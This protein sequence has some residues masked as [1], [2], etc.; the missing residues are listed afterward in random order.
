MTIDKLSADVKEIKDFLLGND[1]NNK[2]GI[3]AILEDHEKQ[4]EG[5]DKRLNAFDE[6]RAMI[7]AYTG[8][9]KWVFGILFTSLVGTVIYFI[10]LKK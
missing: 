7:T 4:L 6:H 10:Q 8:L 5:H 2:K 1:L 9:V 3:S